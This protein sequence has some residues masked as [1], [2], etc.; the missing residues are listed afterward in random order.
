MIQQRRYHD[1]PGW[2]DFTGL[3]SLPL[4]GFW[5]VLTS[6]LG[7]ALQPLTAPTGDQQS[8]VP[9]GGL[10][11]TTAEVSISVLTVTV[12]STILRTS[13]FTV[14][15]T[16]GILQTPSSPTTPCSPSL[17]TTSWDTGI[18]S[19]PTIQST[20]HST[21]HPSK[22][23]YTSLPAIVA[24]STPTGSPTLAK[25]IQSQGPIP[26][27]SP[28]ATS[29]NPPSIDAKKATIIGGLSGSIAGLVLIGVILALCFRKRRCREEDSGSASDS[30][31][32]I[33]PTIPRKWTELTGIVTPKPMPQLLYAAPPATV[34]EDHHII[35]MS[36]QHWPRPYAL[37]HGEGYRDS[38]VPGQLRVTNPDLSRPATPRLSAD[39]GSFLRKQRSA[40]ATLF[41][42]AS[43]SRVSSHSYPQHSIPDI[44]I[45]PPLSRE[46]V[47]CTTQTPS[48]RSYPSVATLSMVQQQPP[49]DPF[50]TPPGEA[51]DQKQRSRRPTLTP[52]QSAASAAS[53]TLSHLGGALNPFK[54]KA[55]VVETIRTVS[56]NSVST[57][58]SR[59][60]RRET[61]QY[62][63]PFDLSVDQTS[64]H[65]R[66]AELERA[67]DGF[68]QD[69]GGLTVYEGT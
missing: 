39:A 11:T 4:S 16:A 22:T 12:E 28:P 24:Q 6:E 15:T 5:S 21:C 47:A 40:L 56:A 45:D 35:R 34:D 43:R 48:F 68:E 23:F 26:T 8:S 67:I 25:S 20:V 59:F 65:T 66:G 2:S 63:N 10:V 30:E 55:N 61:G 27:P 19:P 50:L 52:L 18:A 38:V 51:T 9:A 33:R 3:Q 64:T 36:L 37:G 1:N 62:S 53:R 46:C 44:T 69:C 7:S 29:T 54:T 60:S 17:F 41:T 31:K 14:H 58:S 13:Y 49:E 42:A 32:G 57:L